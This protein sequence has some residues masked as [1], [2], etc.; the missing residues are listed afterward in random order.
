MTHLWGGAWGLNE[1]LRVISDITTHCNNT[2]G[3]QR[4]LL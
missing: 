1:L 3:K 4:L 2:A